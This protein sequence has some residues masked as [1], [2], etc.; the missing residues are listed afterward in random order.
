MGRP[1]LGS[2]WDKPAPILTTNRRIVSAYREI[3]GLE[4]QLS[5][6][7][8]ARPRTNPE[9]KLQLSLCQWIT[10]RKRRGS[11]E[12]RPARRGNRLDPRHGPCMIL[13]TPA[14]PIV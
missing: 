3:L 4:Q 14:A 9:L 8:T 13:D 10:S 6:Q 11:R 2:L 7:Y 5:N 12:P 1:G